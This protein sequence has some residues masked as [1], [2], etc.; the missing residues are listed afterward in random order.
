MTQASSMMPS[1]HFLQCDFN[2][3]EDSLVIHRHFVCEVKLLRG[4]FE[5]Y[6]HICGTCFNKTGMCQVII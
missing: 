3:T 1:M 6:E 4:Y 2:I 5:T